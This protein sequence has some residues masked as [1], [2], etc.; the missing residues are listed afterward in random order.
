MKKPVI[1][2]I[3]VDKKDERKCGKSCPLE[4]NLYELDHQDRDGYSPCA[5]GRDPRPEETGQDDNP[6][7]WGWFYLRSSE[8]IKKEK[9]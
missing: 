6:E 1:I 8:C 2:L 9:K 4:L 5:L 7:S 3:D